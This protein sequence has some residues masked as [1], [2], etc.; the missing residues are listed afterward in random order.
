MSV[1]R[2]LKLWLMGQKQGN[3][4]SKDGDGGAGWGWCHAGDAVLKWTGED[5]GVNWTTV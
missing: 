3:G 5:T 2:S 1:E 4:D